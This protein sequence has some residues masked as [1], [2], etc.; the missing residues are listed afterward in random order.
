M[1]DITEKDIVAFG[2][3]LRAIGI[4]CTRRPG[5]I[6]ELIAGEDV[7]DAEGPSLDDPRFR[8]LAA[9]NLFDLAKGKS[10]AELLAMFEKYDTQ[11]LRYLI[12][13]HRLG[14]V[15][16]KSSGVLSE[17]L[18]DQVMKRGVDVFRSHE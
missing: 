18:V 17:H 10:R 4:A 13:R 1:A 3:V 2:R 14:A 11:Q 15:K 7:G 6:V 8:E 9:L 16:S 5:R 12:R